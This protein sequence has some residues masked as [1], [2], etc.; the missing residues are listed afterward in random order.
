MTK[1]IIRPT[2]PVRR[3]G[4]LK[5]LLFFF[6]LGILLFVLL[7]DKPQTILSP[8]SPYI[9]E[10]YRDGK[11]IQEEEFDSFDEAK[12]FLNERRGAVKRTSDDRYLYLT[13][14]GIGIVDA[15]QT[16]NIYADRSLK[17]RQTYV[18][19]GSRLSLLA[20]TDSVSRIE[21]AGLTGYVASDRLT[22]YPIEQSSHQSY[23]EKQGDRLLHYI[24]ADAGLGGLITAGQAPASL[25]ERTTKY[26]ESKT[27]TKDLR[28]AT[29]LTAKQLDA[30]IR[31]NAPDSPL[32][33]T[34][35]TFKQ[36]ER[37][38]KINAAYL[39]AHAIHESNYG[40][41]EIAQDK[42]NLFGVNATDIAPGKN[43][44]AYTSFEDSI[45]KTGRF[46]A[47]DYLA[48][49]GKYYRGAFLGN[50]AGGMNVFYASDPYWS[51]KIAGI[52]VKMDAV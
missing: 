45:R 22:L 40:R 36:V 11:V 37:D 9:A 44:T 2:R 39:L 6:L 34:G 49:D 29:D 50:K 4:S 16:L 46:I 15:G 38:F 21:I 25:P 18:A 31:K 7:R 48:E 33:G 41:S 17:K 47:R 5:G 20:Y 8:A 14:S 10:L 24:V 19:P 43:A 28:Q 35:K 23:Y 32:I 26:V 12:T 52:L 51:E 13:G 1:R 27:L 3:T 30:Y 42:F